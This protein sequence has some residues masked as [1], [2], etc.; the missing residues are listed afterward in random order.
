MMTT[1]DSR[2]IFFC[3]DFSALHAST[4]FTRMQRVGRFSLAWNHS[5]KNSLFVGHSY[6]CGNYLSSLLYRRVFRRMSHFESTWEMPGG[7][8]SNAKRRRSD[9][10]SDGLIPSPSSGSRKGKRS[11]CI[12]PEC[13]KFNMGGGFCIR[14]GVSNKAAPSEHSIG[15]YTRRN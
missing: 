2:Q 12:T 4:R 13:Q 8:R 7:G 1:T 15:C 10:D 6:P 9:D 5:H 14:H 11:I 3:H